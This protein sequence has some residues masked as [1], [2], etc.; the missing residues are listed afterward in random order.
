MAAGASFA[1]RTS[2]TTILGS[3][4]RPLHL[5]EHRWLRASPPL[6][7]RAARRR[8]RAPLHRPKLRRPL[9]PKLGP[10]SSSARSIA[11]FIS[12]STASCGC[13]SATPSTAL[14]CPLLP[15]PPPPTAS[16]SAA[17]SSRHPKL[18]PPSSW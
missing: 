13:P 1:A 7:Q 9:G 18:R 5:P 15:P 8:L 16:S 11:P 4:R 3:L 10:P 2:P 12:L 6:P 14:R 17:P